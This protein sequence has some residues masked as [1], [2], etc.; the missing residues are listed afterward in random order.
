MDEVTDDVVNQ[1]SAIVIQKR[2]RGYLCRTELLRVKD[3][4]SLEILFK[5][6]D[7][8]NCGI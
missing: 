5:E 2:T 8:Y 7:R 4:M 6:I 3:G 1:K